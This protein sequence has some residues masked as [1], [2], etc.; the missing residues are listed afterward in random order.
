MVWKLVNNQEILNGSKFD[1]SE[2]IFF[3]VRSIIMMD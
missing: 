3:I 2:Y 1:I